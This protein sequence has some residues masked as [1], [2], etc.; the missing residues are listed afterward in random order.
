MHNQSW[1]NRKKAK[2]YLNSELLDLL[3]PL[4]FPVFIL[5]GSLRGLLSIL[6]QCWLPLFPVAALGDICVFILGEHHHPS[7]SAHTQEPETKFSSELAKSCPVT[8]LQESERFGPH[9]QLRIYG[10]RTTYSTYSRTSLL[11]LLTVIAKGCIVY[12]TRGEE[13]VSIEWTVIWGPHA[14][15]LVPE[16]LVLVGALEMQ[17]QAMTLWLETVNTPFAA[18]PR[19]AIRTRHCFPPSAGN[20]EE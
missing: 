16:W 5:G 4:L 13:R 12:G 18:L 1:Q 20:F 2:Y 9:Q 15:H 19:Q 7:L 10:P 8:E 3:E 11:N 6:Q 14:F 17:Y